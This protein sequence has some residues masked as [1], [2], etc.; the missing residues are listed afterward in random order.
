MKF[1]TNSEVAGTKVKVLKSDKVVQAY[2][3]LTGTIEG[4][5]RNSY[6]GPIVT[7]VFDEKELEAKEAFYNKAHNHMRPEKGSDVKLCKSLGLRAEMIEE[8]E[9]E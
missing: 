8:I 9:G 5:P 3:G 1:T 4:S 2:H 6:D 7:V